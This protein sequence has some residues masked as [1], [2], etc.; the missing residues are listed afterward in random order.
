MIVVAPLAAV[1]VGKLARLDGATSPAALT[2][3]ATTIGAV[4]N[5]ATAMAGTLAAFLT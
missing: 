3:A 4:I 2:R 5:L 1:Q